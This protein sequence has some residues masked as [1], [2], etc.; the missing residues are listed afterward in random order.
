MA[1]KASSTFHLG[2]KLPTL[3]WGF[4]VFVGLVFSFRGVGGVDTLLGLKF[5]GFHSVNL[6]G[7]VWFLS[8][9][10]YIPRQLPHCGVC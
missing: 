10:V 2:L 5:F 9:Y 8:C 3:T 7:L 6:V 4:G 1:L